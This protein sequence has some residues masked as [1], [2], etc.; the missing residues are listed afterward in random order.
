MEKEEIR[1][2]LLTNVGNI[3]T[4]RKIKVG[5][6]EKEIGV[7][8]GFL[9]RMKAEENKMP[10]FDTVFRMAEY[11]NVNAESLVTGNFDHP[12]ENLDYLRKFVRQLYARTMAGEF[13]WEALPI[14]DIN[15][16]LR[17][18]EAAR[19]PFG[20]KVDAEYG[21]LQLYDMDDQGIFGLSGYR[22]RNN[23]IKSYGR[24]LDTL[25][26]ADTVFFTK[27]DPNRT[28]YLVQYA[29][30]I[31]DEPSPEMACCF[32]PDFWYELMIDQE[33]GSQREHYP[34]C[35]TLDECRPLEVEIRKLYD[36]LKYHEHD[37]RISDKARGA[38]ED[39]FKTDPDQ[40]PF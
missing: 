26:I 40:V 17:K 34:L 38:I 11:L 2:K 22:A 29:E 4:Q 6:F 31:P 5:E 8:P 30:E 13:K 16:A 18:N 14:R 24:P 39:F 10:G 21:D 33:D 25:A 19:Y 7:Y 20:E 9:S 35:S 37:L 23:R 12:T 28:L 3:L 27:L 1:Q 36:E 32:I 15:D